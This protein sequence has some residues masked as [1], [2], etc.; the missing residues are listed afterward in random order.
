MLH[1]P[2]HLQVWW[3][4]PWADCSGAWLLFLRRNSSKCPTWITCPILRPSP[5]VPLLIIWEKRPTP[6][7]LCNFLHR[8]PTSFSGWGRSTVKRHLQWRKTSVK[9]H[10]LLLYLENR[11]FLEKTAFTFLENKTYIAKLQS[12]RQF[13]EAGFK[14]KK[15]KRNKGGERMIL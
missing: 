12:Y 10:D 14:W 13:I 4:L 7:L 1:L 2:K 9:K 3:P 6:A 8:I 15:R 11:H 5:L